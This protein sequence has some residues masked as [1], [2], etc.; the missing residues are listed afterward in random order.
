ML[1]DF[2]FF[3]ENEQSVTR[4]MKEMSFGKD[5]RSF[6]EVV[7]AD[8]KAYVTISPQHSKGLLFRHHSLGMALAGL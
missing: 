4:A 3:G 5:E 6:A 7:H 2:W 1:K 8:R